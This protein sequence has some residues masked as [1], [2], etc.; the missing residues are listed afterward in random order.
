MSGSSYQGAE[1]SSTSLPWVILGAG[2]IGSLWAAKLFQ[3]S[4]EVELL[5]RHPISTP[6]PLAFR[7]TPSAEP[8][9]LAVPRTTLHE[10]QTPIHKLLLCC[11]APEA[12]QAIVQAQ[13]F[14]AP[15]ALVVLCQNGMGSQQAIITSF[16]QFDIYCLSTTEGAYVA[17]NREVV[18]AG[19][20]TSWLGKLNRNSEP[21]DDQSRAIAKDLSRSEL[22]VK[23]DPCI[24]NRLWLK[25]A[26]NSS[27]NGLTALYGCKNGDLL[28]PPYCDRMDALSRET[29][30]LFQNL[31]IDPGL[32]LIQQVR[33]IAKDTAQNF[34]STY[35]DV[36]RG[37]T[38]ELAFMNGFVIEQA[39]QAGIHLPEHQRLLD[40][41][42]VLGIH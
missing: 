37:K 7:D 11:K 12:F 41:L 4:V 38:T 17:T 31:G 6:T 39:R 24:T 15:G 3:Q 2:A 14:L 18:H 29:I 35:Q 28:R 8:I 30:Q 16:P 10:R 25:L 9:Q 1:A 22:T 40:E 42:A 21:V 19:Y 23:C 27:I 20:G 26:I 5:V 34:S 32:D 36:Q 33:T 13:N